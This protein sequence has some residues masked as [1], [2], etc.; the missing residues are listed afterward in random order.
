M[1]MILGCFHDPTSLDVL[2]FIIMAIY[3]FATSFYDFFKTLFLLIL[4][5]VI[6]HEND[7]FSLKISVIPMSFCCLKTSG[8]KFL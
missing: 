6:A 3:P 5:E 4:N 7:R 2:D 8:K 1:C